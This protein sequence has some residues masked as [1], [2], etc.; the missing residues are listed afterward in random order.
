LIFAILGAVCAV[1]IILSIVAICMYKK[2]HG[3]K[4]KAASQDD[5]VLYAHM[6]HSAANTTETRARTS[7]A[8][9]EDVEY[10]TVVHRASNKK[11]KKYEEEVEYG[12]L[13][14]NTP[15]KNPRQTPKVQDDCVYSQV[16]RGL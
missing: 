4:N 1:L 5:G 14:F 6:N 16:Q 2:T 10:A 8:E 7:R 15:A 3:P 13:V 9:F 11:P 12:E